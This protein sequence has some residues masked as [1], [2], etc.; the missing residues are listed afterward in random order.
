[1][2][3]DISDK[4]SHAD[5]QK[6][7]IKESVKEP[8]LDST[9]PEDQT[10]HDDQLESAFDRLEKRK[11][12]EDVKPGSS[13]A[14]VF[15]ILLALVAIGIG[16]FAVYTLYKPQGDNPVDARVTQLTN[17]LA[18][19]QG[20]V[21]R[22]LNSSA[23]EV[24]LVSKRL[25]ESENKQS[26]SI[27]NLKE[28][29]ESRLLDLQATAGTKSQDWILA[30]V[31]YLLRM[32][33]QRVLMERDPKG[34]L[35]LFRAADNIIADAQGLTAFSLR[36]AMATDIASLEAVNMLD[37]EG[38]YLRLSA[39]AGKVSDLRQIELNYSSPQAPA[40][41]VST[42]ETTI[43]NR[44]WDIVRKAG[45][46]IASLVDFRRD[47]VRI[48]PIL[49]PSEEYFLQQ[50]LILKLQVAQIALLESNQEIY[51]TSIRESIN[52]INKYYDPEDATT[53]SMTSGLEALLA[54]NIQ[55]LMPDVTAS[56][57]AVRELLSGFQQSDDRS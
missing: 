30:E 20:Q 1:M 2:T 10:D 11:Q 47:Q 56:L 15:A 48:S 5:P 28:N 9:T 32:G 4:E 45:N 43:L 24:A 7:A 38:I 35:A 36:Q 50:N 55:T 3:D 49:P 14:G 31:E 25:V 37:K 53:E 13:V 52:W 44:L 19:V 8:K 46:R 51:S 27:A 54:I 26:Q 21:K 23:K 57:R 6:A 42:A 16:S 33:N 41:A 22:Q 40:D 29:L 34:A 39:F 17:D 12:N 18:T